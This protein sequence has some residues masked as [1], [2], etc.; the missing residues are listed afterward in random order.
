MSI[1]PSQVTLADEHPPARR[2]LGCAIGT[3][4]VFAIAVIGG[5]AGLTWLRSG[6]DLGGPVCQATANGQ[7]VSFSPEQMDNAATIVGIAMG[8]GM[9]ARAGTIAIATAIQESK[10]RNINYGDRDSLGLFQQRPSQGWGTEEEI[11]DPEYSTNTFFDALVK[12]PDWEN[13]VVTEVAQA[14]QRSA[15]PEAYADHE[16]EGRILASTLSGHTPAGL[17]CRLDA[18]IQHT[19]ADALRG[20][21]ERHLG[22]EGAV[23]EDGRT[24][25]L[26]V[27]DER[28][29]WSVGQYLVAKAERH[30]ITEVVVGDQAWERASG[31][32]ALEWRAADDPAG[33]TQVRATLTP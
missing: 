27:S 28:Q 26:E 11:L 33:P 14:V 22:V 24:M 10:L 32:S 30:A 17:V 20:D 5:Y 8:R 29:A 18:P 2:R 16:N 21:L 3:I 23:S 6:M 31:P 13:G 12:V 15:Y 19:D 7:T 9:P 4:L 1:P 25:T